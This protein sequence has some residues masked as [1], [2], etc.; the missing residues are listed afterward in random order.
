M[1]LC[2]Q[3]NVTVRRN[4]VSRRRFLRYASAGALAAGTL[5]FR[6]LMCLRADE[7]RQ[8]GRSMILLWMAGGPSQFETFDPKPGTENGGPTQAIETVVPGIRIAQG[9]EQTARVMDQMTLIRSMTNKEGQHQRASYQLHTGY[10]PSGSVKHPSFASAVVKEIAHDG[11]ELPA[12]VSVGNTVGAGFL[13]VDFEPFVVNNPGQL[14]QNVGIPVPDAR[15]ERRLGLL[16]RLEDD[17]AERGA[18]SVVESHR[19][20]YGKASRL[21]KTPQTVAFDFRDEPESLVARYG[22]NQFGRG[23]LLARRLVESGVTFVEVQSNGWDT[24]QDNFERTAQ[25]ASQVDPA[26]AALITDLNDR[27]LLE[28]TVVA[29]MGEFGRTPR[30]N[31][32]TGR[33]HYPRV[34]SAALA[35]GG[36]RGG[37]V[38]GASSSDGSAVA[39]RPVQVADLFASICKSLQVDPRHE[40]ISPLGRPM[41][42][43][44]GGEVVEELFA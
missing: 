4:G 13:G 41:K 33:D 19:Q 38:I 25:L 15:Y 10:L 1:S 43:V 18:A 31:P 11:C 42:I 8:Q 36:I 2:L 7:L 35:G 5:N 3:E 27:G 21:V 44:D 26:L 20:L 22:D 9:W 30:V 29:W 6:D 17:F 40:N 37:Q 34:F 16:D 23:C 14:P 12:F 32:R 24:H 28:R 39:D